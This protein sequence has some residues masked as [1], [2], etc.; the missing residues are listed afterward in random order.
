M[1]LPT[2]IVA[3]RSVCPGVDLPTACSFLRC[4]P[5]AAW[6]C[7]RHGCFGNTVAV[8]HRQMLRGVLAWPYPQTRTLQDVQ[9]LLHGHRCFKDLCSPSWTRPQ[10]AVPLAGVQCLVPACPVQQHRESSRALARCQRRLMAI[11]VIKTFP[12]TAKQGDKEQSKGQKQKQSLTT[13][14]S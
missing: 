6:T 10:V 12:G 13:L 4:V 3:P 7:H 14:G 2:A 11:A 9:G 5:A 8:T 1:D